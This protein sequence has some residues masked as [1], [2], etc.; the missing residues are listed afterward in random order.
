MTA[1]NPRLR[2]LLWQGLILDERYKL[3]SL[4]DCVGSRSLWSALDLQKQQACMVQ[5]WLDHP[6]PQSS[7]LAASLLRQEA[8]KHTALVPMVGI[9]Q[10]P[11]GEPFTVLP[12]FQAKSFANGLNKLTLELSEVVGLSLTLAEAIH[13]LHQA[14]VVHGFLDEGTTYITIKDEAF[15]PLILDAGRSGEVA[16]SHGNGIRKDLSQLGQIF[17][18]LL[19]HATFRTS[20]Q[21]YAR[22][23]EDILA[24]TQ[25]NHSHAFTNCERLTAALESLRSQLPQPPRRE[26]STIPNIPRLEVV[27]TLEAE[28]VPDLP[29]SELSGLLQPIHVLQL[30]K[31]RIQPQPLEITHAP[32]VLPPVIRE[33][34]KRSLVP[35][36]ILGFLVVLA[37]GIGWVLTRPKN[38][39]VVLPDTASQGLADP[40][41][42]QPETP[43]ATSLTLAA[44]P[45]SLAAPSKGIPSPATLNAKVPPPTESPAQQAPSPQ[46]LV[47]EEALEEVPEPLDEMDL[48][49]LKQ[50][51]EAARKYK[52]S[53]HLFIN[54]DDL[55]VRV[56]IATPEDVEREFNLVEQ[57][58]EN[59][60]RDARSKGLLKAV[61]QRVIRD[62]KRKP[63]IE[64]QPYTLY[65]VA[66]HMLNENSPLS[67]IERTLLS[68]YLQGGL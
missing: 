61:K 63:S 45:D 6:R 32:I 55:E 26:L 57:A 47:I 58:L 11:S 56:T 1:S 67:T 34:P 60:R 59:A 29:P 35:P 30:N 23:F 22:E 50:A 28:G 25:S 10:T 24:R 43:S 4:V 40:A 53:P 51:Q 39:S 21:I 14:G 17:R 5:L 15:S 52:E 48:A 68:V 46:V 12:A 9:G 44:K 42:S 65:Q 2:A 3:G 18:Y 33:N 64:I 41:P 19:A 36:L 7:E 66:F 49:I 31:A 20:D 27:Q 13:S 37:V 16:L 38:P 54:Q 8:V 62:L